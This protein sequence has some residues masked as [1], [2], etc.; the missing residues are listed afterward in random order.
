MGV[1]S[2]GGPGSGDCTDPLARDQRLL[3]RLGWQLCHRQ[4]PK[5]H[6]CRTTACCPLWGVGNHTALRKD[7]S[8][9]GLGARRQGRKEMQKEE[10]KGVEVSGREGRGWTGTRWGLPGVSGAG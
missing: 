1:V 4:A 6:F 9:S 3:R 10:E 8:T 5:K 7:S 2:G